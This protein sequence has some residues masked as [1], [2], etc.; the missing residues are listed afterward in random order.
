MKNIQLNSH[1]RKAIFIAMLFALFLGACNKQEVLTSAADNNAER[2]AFLTPNER[3]NAINVTQ[4][5]LVANHAEYNALHVDKDLVNAWGLAFSATGEAWV[6]ST[7][8]GLVKIYDQNGNEVLKPVQIRFN[9]LESGGSPTGIIY[10]NTAGFALR[11]GQL[12]KF[13][14]CTEDG[15]IAGWAQ[16]YSTAAVTMVDNS[17]TGAVYKGLAIARNGG[18]PYLYAADFRHGRIDVFDQSFKP[19]HMSFN[20]PNIPA[21]FAP[22]NIV[23]YRGSLFV[24]YALMDATGKDDVAGAGNGFVS[25]FNTDGSFVRRFATGGALNSPWAVVVVDNRALGNSPSRPQPSLNDFQTDIS[26]S[27]I[28]TLGNAVKVLIGNFGDGHISVYGIDGKFDGQLMNGDVPL[29]IDGLWGLA[30][31][32]SN[33][34]YQLRPYGEPMQPAKLFFTAGPDREDQGLFG[35]LMKN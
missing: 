7:G 28:P 32:N 33:R 24:T 2:R 31:A 4:V 15:L 30:F 11:D 12:S 5:N 10:N 29:A 23:E 18:V 9:G 26:L 14:F 3:T 22:F 1:G 35:Y 16:Q 20:D 34:Q 13:L 19:V 17:E 6:A 25:V 21:G 27:D 8:T